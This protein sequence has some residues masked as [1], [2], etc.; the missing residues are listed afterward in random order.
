M[1]KWKSI[2]AE[3][4]MRARESTLHG[5]LGDEPWIFDG[6]TQGPRGVEELRFSSGDRRIRVRAFIGSL[7]V[8]AR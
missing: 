4:V 8:D 7:E 3:C 2:W 1:T 5:Q 6:F